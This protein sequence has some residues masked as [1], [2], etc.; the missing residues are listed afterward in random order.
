M[1]QFVNSWRRP[2]VLVKA[3]VT[4]SKPRLATFWYY[5][6]VKLVPPTP[7]EIPIAIQSL[8]NIINSAKTETW[9]AILHG[10]DEINFV[11][12]SVKSFP[13]V[14]DLSAI[15]K[16][17]KNFRGKH[18]LTSKPLGGVRDA[19]SEEWVGK[20]RGGVGVGKTVKRPRQPP[21]RPER[22]GRRV[23]P[24]RSRQAH[25]WR[26]RRRAAGRRPGLRF[27]KREELF[28]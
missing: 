9:G 18:Q 17:E 26:A 23:A 11:S 12:R 25:F 13:P 7:A 14:L 20:G 19:G 24:A 1:A 22:R 5:A 21:A 10:S 16:G 2:L 4:Y 15:D 3:A 28:F 8:K 27:Y 6:K